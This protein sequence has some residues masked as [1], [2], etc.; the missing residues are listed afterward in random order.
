[1]RSIQLLLLSIGA[2][3]A[4][5]ATPASAQYIQ[6]RVSVKF[7][8]DV[9]GNRSPATDGAGNPNFFVTDQDVRDEID[10]CNKVLSLWGEGHQL[11]LTEIVNVA[12]RSQWFAVDA[13]NGTNK[14]NLEDA[15][16]LDP[17]GYAL[18]DNAINIYING[19]DD[20]GVCSFPGSGDR[21]MLFGQGSYTTIFIHEIGHF[22]NLCHTQGCACGGCTEAPVQCMNGAI[23][24]DIGDTLLDRACWT[25][26]QISQANFGNV[27]SM[28]NAGQQTAV[29]F[30]WLNI[31][32]YHANLDRF[33][34]QQMDKAIHSSNS[35]RNAVASGFTRFVFTQGNDGLDGLTAANGMRT[36]LGGVIRAGDN[37]Q[38]WITTGLYPENITINEPIMLRARAGPVTIGN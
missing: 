34:W 27:Y 12:N 26:D 28:L 32:S 10:A 30:T 36:I 22:F 13:R 29:D 31:M 3:P 15:A 5:L 38:L 8:L 16:E 20:S 24:D 17:A 2:A 6:W 18:R 7:I 33:T 19:D 35:T 1:M 11:Q 37:D 4:F 21:I 25:R 14:S 9:N 23:A